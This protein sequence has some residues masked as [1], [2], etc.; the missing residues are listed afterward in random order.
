MK[1][2]KGFTLIELL[3]VVLIIG[4]LAGIALPQYRSAVRKA[5]VAEAQVIMR[6]IIDASDRYLLEHGNTEWDSLDDL[7]IDVSTE[8]KYWNIYL[9][10]CANEGCLMIAEPKWEEG[11]DIEY[12]GTGY[13]LGDSPSSGKFACWASSENGRK[14]C[15]QLGGTELENWD[16]YYRI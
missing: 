11:Y 12:G 5:R 1:D 14:I 15:K 7:D 2:K 3:V 8:S 13:V 16:D 9:D 4:I 6:A 10:E